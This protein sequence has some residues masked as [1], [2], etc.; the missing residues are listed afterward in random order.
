M[1]G[2]L[3][4]GG[5]G[6]ALAAALAVQT[7]RIDRLKD[8]IGD[9]TDKITAFKDYE[10]RAQADA[11]TQ[12]DQ[13]RE[14]VAEARLSA[15]RIENLLERP[16]EVDPTGCPVRSVIPADELRGAVQPSASAAETPAEPLH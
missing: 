5:V 13:C 6:L 3:I 11:Q 14:R 9:L 2:Y 12:A 4:A 16:Y 8:H 15:R 7:A 10:A 1:N